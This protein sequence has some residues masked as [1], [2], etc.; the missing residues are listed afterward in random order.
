MLRF[1]LANLVLGLAFLGTLW[2]YPFR[3]DLWYGLAFHICAATMIGG[4]A[5]WYAVTALFQKPLGIPFKTAILPRSKE[6]L[7][8][9]AQDMLSEELLRVS[10]MYKVIKQERLLV[11][12][13]AYLL[14]DNGQY[15]IRQFLQELSKSVLSHMDWEPLRKEVNQ[16]IYKGMDEW[17]ATPLVIL[18][19]RC[20]L[21][22]ETAAVFW[23]HFNRTCQRIIASE[24]VRPYL[25]HVMEAILRRYS[26]ASFM[27]ELALAFGGEGVSPHHLVAL[28]QTKAVEA[29]RGN[30]SLQ[31]PLGR[32]VWGQL[33][34][35]FNRLETNQEWQDFIED[36]KQRW[37]RVAL[38]HWE[39]RFLNGDDI[40]WESL[41]DVILTKV[42]EMGALILIDSDKQKVVE[43]FTLFRLLPL[44]RHVHGLLSRLVGQ[45]LS[46][47][48]A[49][50]LTRIVRDRF[51]HDLQIVRINGS[52]IGAILGGFLY[53]LTL[54]IKGVIG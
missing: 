47:Y 7:I 1:P 52:F 3:Q 21:D 31:S 26:K 25:T 43:R 4:L 27:R 53:I 6:R 29:L 38:E 34:L 51:Y 42:R 24:A 8:K 39:G 13:L 33:L 32:Y 9:M 50:D 22:K 23:L 12:L 2:T 16:A 14:S 49:L 30:E 36:H 5:D 18:F 48:S 11:R 15:Q 19:G 20:M 54:V 10:H 44:L 40:K 37:F 46:H 41:F 35:F 45:E 17:K 28:V